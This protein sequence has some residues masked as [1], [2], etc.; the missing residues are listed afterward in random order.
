LSYLEKA[1]YEEAVKAS[2]K[3]ADIVEGSMLWLANSGMVF[4][5]AGKK[6]DAEEVLDKLQR[7]AKKGFVAPAQFAMIYIGLGEK[8]EAL[9]WL[10]KAYDART[11]HTLKVDPMYDSLRDEP[12]FQKML[13]KMGFKD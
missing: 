10:E 12:R 11:L 9:K 8:E 3:A 13:K 1:M 5:L 7:A 4:G 2:R 6:K